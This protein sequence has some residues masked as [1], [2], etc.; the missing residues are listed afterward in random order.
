MNKSSQEIATVDTEAS[1]GA[2][3]KKFTTTQRITHLAT[4][5]AMALVFKLLGNVLTFGGFKITVVY[6]PWI[7]SALVLGPLG[8]MTVCFATDL[9]GTLIV[10]TGGL[11]IP[12]LVLSNTLFG[13]IMGLCYT[14]PKLGLKLKTLIG[15]VSVLL[16]CTLGLSTLALSDL[17]HIPFWVM[18]TDRLIAQAPMV[19]VNAAAV[20]FL[21]PLLKKMKLIQ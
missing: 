11:P 5:V 3:K 17:Y 15:T 10:P 4:L 9:I 1:R 16:V 12:L 20:V 2:Q 14:I 6:I 13:L 21:F 8:G 18:W 19:A 7:I